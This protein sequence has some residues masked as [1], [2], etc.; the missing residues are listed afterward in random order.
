MEHQWYIK[1][2]RK[3]LEN[4]ISYNIELLWFL[5]YLLLEVNHTEQDIYKG[6][7]KI[8][9]MP[10][11]RIISQ[12]AL[13]ERFSIS[14]SKVHRF[15]KILEE[16][17]I[18]EHQW[19]SSFTIIKL[20]NW[21]TYNWIETQTE[22]KKNTKRT[23]EETKQEWKQWEEWKEDISKDIWSTDLVPVEKI[24]NRNQGTQRIID[25][26]KDQ[27]HQEWFLYDNNKEERNR[28]TIIAKR[29][30]DWGEFIKETPEEQEE[31]IIRWIIS[32][33]L[34]NEYVSKIQS[35]RDFHEKWKKVANAKKQ[36]I[37]EAKKAQIQKN[38]YNPTGNP[39]LNF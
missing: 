21:D 30:S 31:V 6:N 18:L 12:R 39:L 13:W 32:Y 5:S 14:I 4:P 33:S 27:V 35:A 16:E 3:L 23:R 34:Q 17:N 10:W 9:L 15:I 36:E 26:I 28:A 8:H 1:L 24:D 29:Q 7:Q 19:S 11:E 20:L 37:S 22:H 38:K 2:Y 25:I